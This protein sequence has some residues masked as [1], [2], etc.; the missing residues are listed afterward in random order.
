MWLWLLRR[1]SLMSPDRGDKMMV[2]VEEIVDAARSRDPVKMKNAC[3]QH[4]RSASAVVLPM[5]D[6]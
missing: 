5:L 3:M 1:M 4:V 2:E 6:K